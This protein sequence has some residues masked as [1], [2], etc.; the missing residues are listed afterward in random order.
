MCT[1]SDAQRCH[2]DPEMRSTRLYA[3]NIARFHLYSTESGV[4]RR[5]QRLA[6]LLLQPKTIH[7]AFKTNTPCFLKDLVD[8]VLQFPPEWWN[9]NKLS[10]VL[11]R[12]Y[13]MVSLS[14]IDPSAPE[15]LSVE[16][17]LESCEIC[18]AQ[19]PFEDQRWGICPNRHQFGRCNHMVDKLSVNV[20]L[21]SS[22]LFDNALHSGSQDLQILRHL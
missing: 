14:A 4:K 20:M 7:E 9:R 5:S 6:Q 19:I 22:M 8:A 2:A 17:S 11:G 10:R 15:Q 12:L 21:F 16:D 1:Y 18:D 13:K 3:L